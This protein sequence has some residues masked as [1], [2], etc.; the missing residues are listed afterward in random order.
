MVRGRT[1]SSA[2]GPA[3]G[4][5]VPLDATF[6]VLGPVPKRSKT[7]LVANPTARTGKAEKSIRNAMDGLEKVGLNPEFF[8]TQ[9]EGKTVATLADRLEKRRRRGARR[10][11]RRRWNICRIGQGHHPR[12]RAHGRRTCPWRCCPWAPRTIRGAPSGSWPATRPSRATSRS[13]PKAS[14]VG[15]MSARFRPSTTHGEARGSRSVVRQH[16]LRSERSDPRAAQPGHEESLQVSAAAKLLPRQDPLR[17]RRFQL[18][19][20][21]DGHPH[22]LRLRGQRRRRGPRVD[23]L[24]R[25]GRQRNAPLRRATGSSR[26]TPSPTTASSRSFPSA[27]TPTGRAR[28]SKATSTTP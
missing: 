5:S 27:V 3:R 12:A 7:L 9:P 10:V 26:R 23:R 4:Q 28:R 15:S 1:Q 20:S 17:R 19:L 13:S 22:A 16:R 6:D 11:P 24:H 25:P 18:L 2:K 14:S 8:P 21:H